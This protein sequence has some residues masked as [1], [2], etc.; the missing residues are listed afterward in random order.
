MQRAP[1]DA[2]HLPVQGL[3]GWGDAARAVGSGISSVLLGSVELAQERER[4]AVAGELAAFSER[5]RAISD[6]TRA[7]LAGREVQDWDY[8]WQEASGP[9][10]AE[11]VEE[12]PPASRQAGR[13][14][15][16]AYNV[17]ASL[18]AL[19][20]REVEKIGHSRDQWRQ[21]VESAVEDGDEEQAKRWL[22][23]GAGVFVPM[24]KL[25]QE[26]RDV[27]DRARA[28]RWR[29][30]LSLSPV[31][32]LGDFAVADKASLPEDARVMQQLEGEAHKVHRFQKQQLAGALAEQVQQESLFDKEA[33]ESASRAH[34]LSDAQYEQARAVPKPLAVAD[35]CRWQ[36]RIDEC[37]AD[38]AQQ[39]DL[40]LDIATAALPFRE[41][42][43][44]LQRMDMAAGVERSD[45]ETL[46]RQLWWL[47]QRGNFGCPGDAMA[48]QRLADAQRDAL[49]VLAEQ[50][51]EA[52][53]Q[54][55]EA[56]RQNTGRW[57]CFS[58]HQ[59]ET[60]V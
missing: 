41:R 3:M 1:G 36:R 37:A 38:D 34:L 42:K 47:Y 8:A 58:S 49:P 46:S 29:K 60:K 2:A 4:V 32:A 44:L 31:Q 35:L 26:E 5:L 45:R 52:S 11:A 30:S 51:A 14:L 25:G 18:Q 27:A 50:G 22:H 40:K 24:G 33:L 16:E 55:V 54:W 28:A 21:R 48:L 23:S 43:S 57:V 20:D 9:R 53:A 19:R 13:E 7:E 15:A 17:R 56:L 6:E 39:A 59:D 12:L 10:L